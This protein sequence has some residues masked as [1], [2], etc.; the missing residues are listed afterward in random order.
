MYALAVIRYRRPLDEVLIHYDAHHAYLQKLK[1]EGTLIAA[2]PLDPRYAGALLVRVQD[3]EVH[4][5]LDR[6]RDGDPYWKAGVAQYELLPWNVRTG[7][8]DLDRI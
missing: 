5:A 4:A 8:E 2:G 7:R 1:A 6:I 3:T